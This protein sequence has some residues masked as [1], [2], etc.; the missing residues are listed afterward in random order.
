MEGHLA[1]GDGVVIFTN[2]A[3]GRALYSE[4]S[5]AVAVSEKWAPALSH[6]VRIP[7]IALPEAQLK[8]KAG[9]YVVQGPRG[10]AGCDPVSSTVAYRVVSRNGSLYLKGESAEDDEPREERL[11]PV[12]ASHFVMQ[13]DGT[14]RIEFVRDYAGAVSGMQLRAAESLTQAKR[15]E[16]S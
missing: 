5:R 14:M 2:S 12:D 9:L 6:H 3:K 10:A 15:L 13:S 4:V 16:K 8:E 11:I 1:T 7:A